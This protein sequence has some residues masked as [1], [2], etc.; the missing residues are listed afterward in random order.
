MIRAYYPWPGIWFKNVIAR[1]EATKQSSLNN[2]II[3]LLPEGKIQVEGKNQMS[4]KDFINGYGSEGN[5]L[6]DKLSLI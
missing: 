3:K 6:L 5:S 1:S 4:Y 2:K